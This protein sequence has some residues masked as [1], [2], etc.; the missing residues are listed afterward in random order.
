MYHSNY[1]MNHKCNQYYMILLSTKYNCACEW[2]P[3][4]LLLQ[5]KYEYCLWELNVRFQKESYE[6]AKGWMATSLYM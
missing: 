2:S 1:V 3:N 5:N 6:N 4:A